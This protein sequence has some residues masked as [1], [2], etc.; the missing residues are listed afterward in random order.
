MPPFINAT[1]HMMY[2]Q[3]YGDDV[4]PFLVGRYHNISSNYNS[5]GSRSTAT[6]SALP[7]ST[8]ELNGAAGLMSMTRIALIAA[9]LVHVLI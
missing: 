4:V 7:S 1:A 8:A 6:E 2:V 5:T 3:N 9:L